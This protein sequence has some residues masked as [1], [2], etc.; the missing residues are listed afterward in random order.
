MIVMW[1]SRYPRDRQGSLVYHTIVVLCHLWGV[2]TVREFTLC[3]RRDDIIA[4]I[5]QWF[6]VGRK[7]NGPQ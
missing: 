2:A 7:M 4:L 1:F 3:T 5:E 6:G